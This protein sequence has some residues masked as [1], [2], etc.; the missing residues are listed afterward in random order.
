MPAADMHAP[1]M[2]DATARFQ[3]AR[4]MLLGLAYRLLGSRADAEDAVQDTFLRWQASDAAGIANAE[5]WLTAVCTRRCLDLLQAADRARVDYVGTWLPEPVPTAPGDEPAQAAALASSLTTAFLLALQRLTP[6]ERAAYLLHEI[7]DRPYAEVATALDLQAPACR[8]LVSRARAHLAAA[9]VRH[10]TPPARQRQLLDAFR[11]AI[12]TGS[13]AT[14]T[15]L[16]AADVR[17]SADGGGK[18]VA[19]RRVMRGLAEVRRFIEAGLHVWWSP[20]VLEET[21]LNGQPGFVLRDGDTASVVA[22]IV[23]GWDADGQVGDLFIMRNPDKLAGLDRPR[24][25]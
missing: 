25:Q 10:A 18:V 7:F 9:R 20:H 21:T 5:A 24:V 8:Q 12:A 11:E 22:T 1:E 6:K 17:L 13:T 19:A 14:L 2:P 15:G 4:P 3:T 23:F 16:L